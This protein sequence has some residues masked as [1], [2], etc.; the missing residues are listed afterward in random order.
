MAEGFQLGEGPKIR[1][2]PL[3]PKDRVTLRITLMLSVNMDKLSTTWY[4]DDE[5]PLSPR[6]KSVQQLGPPCRSICVFIKLATYTAFSHLWTFQRDFVKISKLHLDWLTH[7][8]YMNC[9]SSVSSKWMI[10]LPS[11]VS[12]K[13]MIYLPSSVSSKWMIYLPSSV[14]SKWMIYS[15]V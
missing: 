2:I 15:C 12:S 6:T 13:W 14:S 10:H 5:P 7:M 3:G 1:Y 9:P 8:K 4:F 11:S